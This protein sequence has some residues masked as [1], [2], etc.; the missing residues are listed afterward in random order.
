MG[1]TRH[2]TTRY[3]RYLKYPFLTPLSLSQPTSFSGHNWFSWHEFRIKNDKIKYAQWR[4][5]VPSIVSTIPLHFSSLFPY[6][7]KPAPFGSEV[8]CKGPYICG[9]FRFFLFSRHCWNAFLRQVYYV[10]IECEVKKIYI[11]I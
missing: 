4:Y 2:N 1:I 3:G 6:F 9:F 8:E 10:R 7:L 11:K 5:R